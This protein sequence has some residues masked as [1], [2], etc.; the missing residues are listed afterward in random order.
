MSDQLQE[1]F[2]KYRLDQLLVKFAKF[3]SVQVRSITR[4]IVN[5][6]SDD[7]RV[8]RHA[9]SINQAVCTPHWRHTCHAVDWDLL[10]WACWQYSGRVL[11]Q[12]H[13]NSHRQRQHFGTDFHCPSL[14]LTAL[15]H[16]SCTSKRTC[17]IV[18]FKSNNPKILI[19]STDSIFNM[20][21]YR[22]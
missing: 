17:S 1:K 20:F 2:V 11:K 21:I 3:K 16:L 12:R 22:K 7:L 4:K 14:T 13:V 9:G 6:W 5:N 18:T 15:W 10:R 8:Y 19:R